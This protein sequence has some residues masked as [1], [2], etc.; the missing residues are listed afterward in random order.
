MEKAPPHGRVTPIVSMRFEPFSMLAQAQSARARRFFV[1]LLVE[2]W[3]YLGAGFGFE[4]WHDV[5]GRWLTIYSYFEHAWYRAR[6]YKH[7]GS[8]RPGRR[9]KAYMPHLNKIPGFMAVLDRQRV[10]DGVNQARTKQL[11][12][13]R[14]TAALTGME[15]PW[16]RGGHPDYQIEIHHILSEDIKRYYIQDPT[17]DARPETCLACNRTNHEMI[18]QMDDQGIDSGSPNKTIETAINLLDAA[19]YPSQNSFHPITAPLSGE[20]PEC[21]GPPVSFSLSSLIGIPG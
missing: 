18:H 2:G 13:Y 6:V 4:V 9:W 11:F 1:E 19:N 16:V 15:I 12:I 7:T 17:E 14:I 8:S 10:L 5:P 3:V 21:V 20:E